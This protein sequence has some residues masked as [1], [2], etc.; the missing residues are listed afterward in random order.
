MAH[1]NFLILPDQQTAS[2]LHYA[3]KL[4]ETSWQQ[5]QRTFIMTE[6]DQ[7]SIQLDKQLWDLRS[8]S[9]IPHGIATMEPVDDQH[10]ILISHLPYPG[11][12]V[13][14]VINLSCRPCE[15]TDENSLQID[16]ILNQQEQRKQQARENYKIYRQLG[17]TLQHHTLE[18]D[19]VKL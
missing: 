12:K 4:A 16:E 11:L 1:V 14:Y 3:C 6:D 8:N 9:F 10:P 5:G 2:L 19:D 18:S 15:L 17:Y 7:Q 13:K